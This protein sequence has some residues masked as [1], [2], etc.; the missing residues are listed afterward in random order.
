M[1]DAPERIW[2]N[3]QGRQDD[4]F[5]GDAWVNPM[6]GN[7]P[8]YVLNDYSNARVA[9]ALEKAAGICSGMTGVPRSFRSG[10]I[11]ALANNAKRAALEQVVREAV[12]AE[13]ERCAK[14]AE[15]V[16]GRKDHSAYMWPEIIAAA[17]RKEQPE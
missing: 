4:G 1:T 16:S 14:I 3:W 12:E 9:A 2:L 10:D 5:A 13:R 8:D 6:Q 15:D 11:R 17:I 7:E